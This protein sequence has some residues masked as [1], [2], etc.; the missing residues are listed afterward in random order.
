MVVRVPSSC[1]E[2]SRN[3]RGDLRLGEVVHFNALFDAFLYIK[4]VE[5]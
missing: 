2:E 1:T 5:D 4:I 3:L